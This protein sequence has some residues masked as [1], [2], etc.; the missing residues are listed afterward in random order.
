MWPLFAWRDVEAS[1]HTASGISEAFD[2]RFTERAAH[3]TMNGLWKIAS[4]MSNPTVNDEA[5]RILGHNHQADGSNEATRA[6][7]KD[8]F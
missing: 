8:C 1:V 5:P 6:D 2:D 3:E 7:H 4:S